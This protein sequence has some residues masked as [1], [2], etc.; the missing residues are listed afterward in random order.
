[1]AL[2][3]NMRAFEMVKGG[4]Q[5]GGMVSCAAKR[6]FSFK[7]GAE[8]GGHGLTLGAASLGWQADKSL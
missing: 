8:F 6:D 5:I 7:S 4:V 2:P 3:Q 1:M